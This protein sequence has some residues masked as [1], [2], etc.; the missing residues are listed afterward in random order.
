MAR[1]RVLSTTSEVTAFL[2]VVGMLARSLGGRS[3]ASDLVRGL[4]FAGEET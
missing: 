2:A 1:G 4:P 3:D